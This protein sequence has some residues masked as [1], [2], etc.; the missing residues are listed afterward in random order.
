MATIEEVNT[1]HSIVGKGN[2]K[3]NRDLFVEE[4]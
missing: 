3:P 4:K 2:E 1:G